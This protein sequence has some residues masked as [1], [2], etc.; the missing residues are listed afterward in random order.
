[1][2]VWMYVCMDVCM[3]VCIYIYICI[4]V[5]PANSARFAPAGGGRANLRACGRLLCVCIY[6]YI[7]M[8][9]YIYIERERGDR[10]NKYP[11]TMIPTKIP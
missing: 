6:I 11:T 2:Y 10:E 4:G 7:Y 9:I 8:Y 1:M 3:Y 5:L